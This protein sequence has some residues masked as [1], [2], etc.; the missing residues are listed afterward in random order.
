MFNASLRSCVLVALVASAV[1]AQ[2]PQRTKFDQEDKFRQLDEVLPTPNM[3]RTASGAPGPNYWQQ[4]ADYVIKAT[5][6]DEN[7]RL[8]GTETITYHNN[9]PD[10]LSYLWLQ[11]ERNM[12]TPDSD[13]QLTKTLASILLDRDNPDALNDPEA[14]NAPYEDFERLSFDRVERML[15][16]KHFDGGYKITRVAD[17]RGK[18]LEYTVVRTMMRIDLPAPL[19]PGSTMKFSVEWNFN[20]NDSAILNS[21]SAAE[22]FEE[23]GNWIYEMA[24]WFP[25]MAAYTDY[26]GWQHKQ[27]L[28]RG[29]FTLEFGDY[30]VSL[31]VP[32][33][34]IVTATGK[35][36]NPKDVLT[37][38]QRDRLKKAETAE[39]PMFIIT[40]EEAKANESDGHEGTKTWRFKAERVRDF[41]FANSRKFIWDAMGHTVTE[42]DGPGYAKGPVMAMSFYPNEAEPLW[43]KYSTHAIVHTLDVFSRYSFR[44]PYPVAISV[45]GPAGGMEYPM[46]CFNGPRPEDDGTYTARTKYGLISVI[47]HEVGHFFYPMIINSDE[48][49]WTWMD[50]GLN[51]FVQFIAESEWEDDYPSRR[52][53][54][55]KMVPY[56][57]SLNQVPI[58][59]NSE[60]IIQFGANAYGKPATALNVLRETIMGRELFDHA[61]RTYGQR[62]WFKRP[63]PADFFRTME[64]ASGIDLDWFWRG[65]FYSTDHVDISIENVRHFVI[66]TEDPAIEKS[67]SRAEDDAI[68][69]TKSEA[70]YKDEPKRTD[71]Y[72]DLIDFYNEYDKFDVT[73]KDRRQ[74]DAYLDK[75]DDEQRDLLKVEKNFYIIDLANIGGLVMP[76]ILEMHYEDGSSEELRIPAEI[77]RS[78]NRHVSKLIMSDKVLERVVLDP[79]RETADS[80][81]VSNHWPRKLMKSR[82]QLY[83]AKKEYPNPMQDAKNERERDEASEMDGKEMDDKTEP[84]MD[85][86]SDG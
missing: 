71:D 8:V 41:A 86:P 50:E 79:H 35:L 57:T 65:W 75:L 63:E 56:M 53:E 47:I 61:F 52:G 59:T 44:Y 2:S 7:Q 23:D 78:N 28:G 14:D 60:S 76:V 72:P 26:G 70:R 67:R 45:N 15:A 17:A 82:F 29:E 51:T 64:D 13:E 43:S 77:W 85:T 36:Q 16:R 6:D 54:P 81:E 22:Y 80:D 37:K 62:W 66:D 1:A 31:T 69:V 21:R 34:H 27:F 9:S 84:G 48:R 18:P 55:Y 25:R 19:A 12:F 39:N 58:M 30:D 40:P 20:I 10:T 3:F 42:G 38:D 73:P 4:R 74:F 68:A 49:Q 33:D 5:I 11:L 32:A 24:H 83:K 46:I